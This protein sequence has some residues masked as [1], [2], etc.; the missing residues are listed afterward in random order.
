MLDFILQKTSTRV[1]PYFI[2]VW[3]PMLRDDPEVT[4]K[5][6]IISILMYASFVLSV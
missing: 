2:D 6:V 5:Q 4:H 1:N 3:V